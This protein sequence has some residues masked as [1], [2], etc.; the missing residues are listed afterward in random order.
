MTG[1]VIV[2]APSKGI[3]SHTLAT[4]FKWDK[5]F[6][7]FAPAYTLCRIARI[8]GPRDIHSNTII[9]LADSSTLISALLPCPKKLK[10]SATAPAPTPEEWE[11][12]FHMQDKL[13]FPSKGAIP[14][15]YIADRTY[16]LSVYHTDDNRFNSLLGGKIP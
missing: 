3:F 9:R 14:G 10:P 11:Q 6:I 15:V 4:I 1:D 16:I 7:L 12:C 2:T 8:L 13:L 5:P